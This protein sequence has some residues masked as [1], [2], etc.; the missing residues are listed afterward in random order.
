MNLEFRINLIKFFSIIL[1]DVR[2][3]NEIEE[4]G[5]IPGSYNV[6][7]SDIRA[8]FHLSKDEFKDKY[9]LELPSKRA[10]NLVLSCR[11]I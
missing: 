3:K 5:K 9:G 11:L 7:L 4:D 8:A 2:N 10:N 6:P 1:I